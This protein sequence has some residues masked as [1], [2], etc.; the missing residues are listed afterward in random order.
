MEKFNFKQ[1][2][3]I[4]ALF[5]SKLYLKYLFSYVLVLSI[6]LFIIGIF[7]FS[8]FF[9][10]LKNELEKS[11]LAISKQIQYNL[12]TDLKQLEI[13][14]NQIYQDPILTAYNMSSPLG[15]LAGIKELEKMISGNH[16]PYE[17]FVYYDSLNKV[18][19]SST[20]FSVDEFFQYYKFAEWN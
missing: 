14:A 16:L 4:P 11:N 10:V 6:P 12:D 1:L 19:S 9:N 20:A 18:F 2:K 15:A 8:H 5:K 17:V 7:L 3:K 13:V